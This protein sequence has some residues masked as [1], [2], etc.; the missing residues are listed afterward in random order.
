MSLCSRAGGVEALVAGHQ[1]GPAGYRVR[2]VDVAELCAEQPLCGPNWRSFLLGGR[3]PGWLLPGLVAEDGGRGHERFAPG[4]GQNVNG[5]DVDAVT[6][7]PL[8]NTAA[9]QVETVR[10]KSAVISKPSLDLRRSPIGS[11]PGHYASRR[12]F[13]SAARRACFPNRLTAVE[14]DERC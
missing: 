10:M 13:T 6:S 14:P 4:P 5:M 1:F 7:I 3:R 8:T 11:M 12:R 9:I 2:L